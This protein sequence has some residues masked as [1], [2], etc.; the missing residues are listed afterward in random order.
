[1]HL[2]FLLQFIQERKAEQENEFNESQSNRI[3]K[4]VKQKMGVYLGKNRF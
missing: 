3:T 2:A 1:M 4:W